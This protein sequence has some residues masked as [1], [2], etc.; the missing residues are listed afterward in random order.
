[1]TEIKTCAATGYHQ[2]CSTR[3]CSSKVQQPLRRVAGR[4]GARLPS[5]VA[6]V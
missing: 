2:A 5:E 3:W 1:M 4:A 6:G